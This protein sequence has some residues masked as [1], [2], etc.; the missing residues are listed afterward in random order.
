MVSQDLQNSWE[1]HSAPTNL[2]WRR[3]RNKFELYQRI[4]FVVGPIS[5]SWARNDPESGDI[6]A[7]KAYFE[8][9][10]GDGSL[11]CMLFADCD[12][13]KLPLPALGPLMNELR[14]AL[15]EVRMA[16]ISADPLPHLSSL[17]VRHSFMNPH[18]A[19]LLREIN[20]GITNAVSAPSLLCVH[21]D[22][23]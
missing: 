14:D 6:Q 15:L 22:F 3:N 1:S 2:G 18:V 19:G 7:L 11:F 13:A 21:T 4:Y 23:G 12:G 8:V 10:I 17:L 20:G 9:R 16:P 5:R